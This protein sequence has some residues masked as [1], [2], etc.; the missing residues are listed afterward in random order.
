MDFMTTNKDTLVAV[1]ETLA[2]SQLRASN[3]R[4]I[5]AVDFAATK[6]GLIDANTLIRTVN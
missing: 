1:T 2:F 6:H 3:P 4:L 5:R